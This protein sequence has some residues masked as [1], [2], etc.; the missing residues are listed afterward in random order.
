MYI[1]CLYTY[2]YWVPA[3]VPFS[4]EGGI[5]PFVATGR[6][7]Q[8]QQLLQFVCGTCRVGLVPPGGFILLLCIF[9]FLLPKTSWCI[10]GS[11]CFILDS[12]LDNHQSLASCSLLREQSQGTGLGMKPS[13]HCEELPCFKIS[14]ASISYAD[15]WLTSLQP[16]HGSHLPK[17]FV[18]V[19]NICYAAFW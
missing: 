4:S 13:I 18:A 15:I 2:I 16:P 11:Y 14:V 10:S 1:Y 5:Q 19:L 7:S 6:I 17:I 12:G 3:W 8:N 9:R